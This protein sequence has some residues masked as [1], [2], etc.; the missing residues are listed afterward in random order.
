MRSIALF[1]LAVATVQVSD[2]PRVLIVTDVEG[3]GG[4]NNADVE[5]IQALRSAG[6]DP[7]AT[8]DDGKTPLDMAPTDAVRAMLTDGGP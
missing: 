5:T 1:L 8:N 3:V 7:T 2:R 4:V 6:A